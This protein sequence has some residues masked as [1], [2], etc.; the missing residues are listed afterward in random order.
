MV[1]SLKGLRVDD[2]R[3]FLPRSE[4]LALVR[5]LSRAEKRPVRAILEDALKAY[6]IAKG[7]PNP[8]KNQAQTK[9]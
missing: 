2:E 5:E 6:G 1:G 3:F 8:I 4:A 9:K 7:Y